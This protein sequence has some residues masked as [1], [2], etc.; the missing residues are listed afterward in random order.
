VTTV[1]FVP[2]TTTA[3][4]FQPT[5]NGITYNVVVTW[6]VF[7]QRY[8][9]NVY[10]LGGDLI[11]CRAM[12]SSG[13]TLQASLSWNSSTLQAVATTALAH[14]VPI[15]SVANLTVSGTNTDFDGAWQAQ[16]TGPFTLSYA[17]ANPGQSAPVAGQVSF[18]WDLVSGPG[19]GPL[20]FN[21]A[22]QTFQY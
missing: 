12:V 14:N 5:L 16:A 17:L 21:Y 18:L 3:F 10:D 11:L 7:G 22:A 2:S 1:P 19:I 9:I 8:Y 15:G 20:Y 13:P 6:N 4:S